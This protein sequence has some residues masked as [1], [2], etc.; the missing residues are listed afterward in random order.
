MVEISN[1]TKIPALADSDLPSR[2]YARHRSR[3][4]EVG[5]PI[6]DP[7]L[8]IFSP[9]H[10]NYTKLTDAKEAVMQAIS[11]AR[12]QTQAFDDANDIL[13]SIR[14]SIEEFRKNFP[15]FP[16]GSEQRIAY[17]K[18]INGLRQALEVVTFPPSLDTNNHNNDLNMQVTSL[19][20]LDPNDTSDNEL[21]AFNTAVDSLQTQ[22]TGEKVR[23][24]SSLSELISQ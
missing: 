16:P 3:H 20:Y 1:I 6:A 5:L 11:S 15:P 4:E 24:Q 12:A 22:I 18:G 21:E 8:Q 9:N 17:L 13:V 7:L 14:N 10:G 2:T 19:P 23:F